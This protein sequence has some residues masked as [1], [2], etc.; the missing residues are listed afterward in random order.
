MDSPSQDGTR[1]SSAQT[2][3]LASSEILEFSFDYCRSVARS[4]ARNFY[5]AVRLL[6]RDKR[7]AIC[8]IYTF[9]RHADDLC[10]EPWATPGAIDDWREALE[11]AL[12]GR[13]DAHPCWPA[14]HA[15]VNRYQIPH[16]LFSKL[17]DGVSGDREHR[18]FRTFDD[19]YGYCYNVASVV[20]L[21]TIRVLGSD[22]PTAITLAEKCGIAFQLTNILRDIKEDLECNRMYL[23]LEDLERFEVTE[24]DLRQGL[25]NPKLIRLMAFEADRARRFYSEAL[26]LIPLVDRESRR[27]L[28][29]LII[30]YSRLLERIEQQGYDVFS[31]RVQLS[32]LEKTFI[33]LSSFR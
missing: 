28:R 32:P 22:S 8:V 33:A 11:N 30:I 9:M 18:R 29:V 14:L 25:P 20:G 27:C 19:L 23:P 31:Q 5:Y 6:P 1:A 4:R 10:D 17:I 3:P 2:A 13:F 15:T 24:D 7:D 21:A 16:E 26:P 12:K